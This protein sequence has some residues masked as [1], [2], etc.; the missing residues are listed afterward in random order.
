MDFKNFKN[1]IAGSWELEK[2]VCGE[3]ITPATIFP[4]GNGNIITFSA[5]G[6]FERRK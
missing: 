5:D 2:S 3:C 4:Q 1:K 6:A